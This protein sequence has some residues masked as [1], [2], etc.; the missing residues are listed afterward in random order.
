M[1]DI[2]RLLPDAVANQIAAGEVVQRPAS[3]V[4]ELLENAIDAGAKD[5]Q[6]F[7]K[8]AGRTLI[9][10]VDNGVGM[11]E[12]D[13]RMSFE[14]HATSKLRNADDLFA[15]RTM[16]FRGEALASIAS[17]AQ[18]EMKTRPENSELG[19]QFCIEGSVF[20][21][22]QPCQ[23]NKGTS[24]AVKNLF[25]NVPARRNF[26]KS[27]AVEMKHITEEF[28]HVALVH[29]HI[30]FSLTHNDKLEYQLAA[31]N[32][33]QRIIALFG[34]TYEK[35]LMAFEQSTCAVKISGFIGKPEYAM[36]TKGDQYFFVN[37]RYIR[38]PYM[39]HAIMQ[40][41]QELLVG[42]T[43]P[44]YFIQFEIDPKN[45][46]VNIHPTKTEIKF[47]DDKLIYGMLLA[48]VRKAIGIHNIKP[49]ID[50]AVES[51]Y[52]ITPMPK[53]Y[54]P[55]SPQVKV[56]SNYNPFDTVPRDN[57]TVYGATTSKKE[58][59]L[60]AYEQI[61][62]PSDIIPSQPTI[63]YEIS[64]SDTAFQSFQ[65][66]NKYI[67]TT[68]VEGLLI[69]DQKRAHQRIV[70]E[71]AMTKLQQTSQDT[72]ASQQLLFPKLIEV[73]AANADI[74]TDIQEP[75]QRLGWKIEPFGKH[76]FN[77][78]ASTTGLEEQ[79]VE[80]CLLRIVEDYKN[81]RMLNREDKNTRIALSQAKS[82]CIP[83]GQ[84]LSMTEQIKLLRDLFSCK[85]PNLSPIG[86]PTYKLFIED[87][88]QLALK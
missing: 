2:I 20:K 54:V 58:Q 48:A 34:D 60:Q 73:T 1:A 25:F 50:F 24:I 77:I 66:A 62:Q 16:G 67:V 71:Q 39:H 26:L 17:I 83:Y 46:D 7:V 35:K 64:L 31:A 30:K 44:S 28:S 9:H 82:T 86:E 22:Q 81:D 68:T 29:P 38:H 45:I 88:I 3:V 57:N 74:L 8:D 27:D 40:A 65:W 14:R 41:F 19:T 76:T 32:F 72:G 75:L 49:S 5:I 15:L 69:V 43:V 6:L 21:E 80:Q 56:N 12:T 55:Q 84:R 78:L 79:D 10:I 4:K 70:F 52:P 13:A 47:S 63:E 37:H 23:C 85:I 36:K 18:V 61:Q 33:K 51:H 42:Q 11:S 87:E 53:G 59:Y